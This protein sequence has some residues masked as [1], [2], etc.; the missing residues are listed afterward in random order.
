MK[1]S[2]ARYLK[3]SRFETEMTDVIDKL[4]IHQK[5]S[6]TEGPMA[7]MMPMSE[8]QK[9]QAEGDIDYIGEGL[10]A[11]IPNMAT[12]LVAPTLEEEFTEEE[13]NELSDWLETEQGQRLYKL[14]KKF[15]AAIDS[16]AGDWV[17]N[18]VADLMAKLLDTDAP[19]DDAPSSE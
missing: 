7:A 15:G 13:V 5:D 18:K 14:T 17:N 6:L 10:T 19:E 11:A 1:D 12:E 4:V 16:K 3:V 2:T 9:A 8:D